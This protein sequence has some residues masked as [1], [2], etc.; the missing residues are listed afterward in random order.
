VVLDHSNRAVWGWGDE[1]FPVIGFHD[2]GRW[3]TY[4]I[5]NGV[6]QRGQLGVAWGNSRDNLTNTAQARSGTS[7]FLFGDR[8]ALPKWM[9]TSM[10]YLPMT[11]MDRM[12]LCWKYAQ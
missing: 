12:D 7:P 4:Y 5:P 9:T 10:P 8:V 1:L 3:F 11:S 2:N 6:P